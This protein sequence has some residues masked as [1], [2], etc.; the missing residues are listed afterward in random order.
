MRKKYEKDYKGV[1]EKEENGVG[2]KFYVDGDDE[3]V[4][5]GLDG[6]IGGLKR[7]EEKV[8]EFNFI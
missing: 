8:I 6:M 5:M 2:K 3:E 1:G 4:K 7:G